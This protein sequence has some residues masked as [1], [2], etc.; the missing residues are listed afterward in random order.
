MFPQGF[1]DTNQVCLKLCPN[2]PAVSMA[3]CCVP[4]GCYLVQWDL[5]LTQ[6]SRANGVV[7]ANFLHHAGDLLRIPLRD[8][9]TKS[10]KPQKTSA[11]VH[12]KSR[13]LPPKMSF[14]ANLRGHF[15]STRA[16]KG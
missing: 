11:D 3:P 8:P 15:S 10:E 7:C 9:P 4:R 2:T 14:S 13:W 6:P 16:P 1:F 5:S 12:L